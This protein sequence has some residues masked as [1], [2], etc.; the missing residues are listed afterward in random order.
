MTASKLTDRVEVYQTD[1]KE[2]RWTL[3][4]K[5]GLIIG[6]SSEGYKRRAAA[7]KN[8]ERVTGGKLVDGRLARS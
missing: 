8:L 2:W 7:V 5:N 4:G 1:D 3:H 6:A